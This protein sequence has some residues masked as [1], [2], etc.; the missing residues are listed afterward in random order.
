MVQVPGGGVG[1]EF[2]GASMWDLAAVVAELAPATAVVGVQS[3][4]RVS[5]RSAK[6]AWCTHE[7]VTPAKIGSCVPRCEHGG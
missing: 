2:G 7:C 4:C 3:L 5:C 1:V 6:S